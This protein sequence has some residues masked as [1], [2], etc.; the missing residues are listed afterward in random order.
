M[1]KVIHVITMYYFI[2]LRYVQFVNHV[3]AIYYY[4]KILYVHK[5]ITINIPVTNSLQIIAEDFALCDMHDIHQDVK[6]LIDDN[7]VISAR[8][9][10]R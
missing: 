7:L 1:S 6:S 3:F 8:S 9:H 5:N 4:C 10:C 2:I